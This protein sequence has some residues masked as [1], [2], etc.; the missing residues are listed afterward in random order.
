MLISTRP[1]GRAFLVRALF[2]L[3]TTGFAL[4]L[5]AA[6]HGTATG[7]QY[8][9]SPF[10]FSITPLQEEPTDAV[11]LLLGDLDQ[12]S[13]TDFLVMSSGGMAAYDHWGRPLWRNATPPRYFAGPHADWVRDDPNA[14]RPMASDLHGVVADVDGDGRNEFIFLDLTGYEVVALD[15]ATG[16]EKQ[17]IDLRTVPGLE[18]VRPCTHVVPARLFHPGADSGIVVVS[19]PAHVPFQGKDNVLAFDWRAPQSGSAWQ[20]EEIFGICY[21]PARAIDLDGDGWDEVIV[22]L[23]V[24]DRHGRRLWQVEGRSDQYSTLQIGNVLPGASLEVVI[25][26][27]GHAGTDRGLYINGFGPADAAP[28]ALYLELS[29]NTHSATLGRFLAD[30]P[31]EQILIRNNTHRGDEDVRRHR[32]LDPLQPE[33]TR[34]LSVPLLDTAWKEVR[35]GGRATAEYPRAID[36]DGDGEADILAVERHTPRPRASV[37]HWRTGQRLMLTQHQG[38]MEAGVR[39]CDVSGDAREEVLVWNESEVAVYFDSSHGT[40]RSV[41]PRRADRC[42]QRLKSVGNVIYNAP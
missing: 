7:A 37:H 2:L 38:M 26:E 6:D 19:H 17:R 32:I 23:D 4:D 28:A 39:A 29:Q 11:M 41:P 16:R 20:H 14:L 21:A 40:D 31:L 24:F 10:V 13:E 9:Q 27:Y 5:V 1:G 34:E 3:T 36:W 35:K 22:G 30:S 15:G 33:E 42:Y 12:D 8:P 25:G 18:N